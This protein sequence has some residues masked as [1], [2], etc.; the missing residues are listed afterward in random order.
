MLIILAGKDRISDPPVFDIL[1]RLSQLI[2]KPFCIIF[3]SRALFQNFEMKFTLQNEEVAD[4]LKAWFAISFAF[5]ILLNKGLDFDSGFLSQMLMAAITVGLGFLLHEMAHKVMA[6]KF[7][8]QARFHS[9]DLMLLATVAMSF[10]GFVF[11]A[12]GAVFIY[13]KVNDVKNGIISAVGPLTNI[14]L[15]IL[16]LAVA[17]TVPSLSE[18]ALYGFSINS[19]LAVFNML[20]I[21][22]LDGTKVLKWSKPFYFIMLAFSFALLFISF[23]M[24]GF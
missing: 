20:P 8:V 16:F 22:G 4:L 15:A 19:W 24:G 21:F 7:N 12:P 13:G 23:G 10:F 11:A 6:L 9:F 14:F 5:A 2:F 3:L 17:F 18:F 1:I